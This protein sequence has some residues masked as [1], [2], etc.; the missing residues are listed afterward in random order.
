V[1]GFPQPAR[2]G[3]AYRL[4]LYAE[5][6]RNLFVRRSRLARAGPP[7]NE[8]A[9]SD[10]EIAEQQLLAIDLQIGRLENALERCRAYGGRW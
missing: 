1:L 3:P 6:P 2:A 7:K 4:W 10:A 9:R 8:A 5:C